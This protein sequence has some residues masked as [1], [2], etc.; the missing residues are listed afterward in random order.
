MCHH[1]RCNKVSGRVEI[2]W[3]SIFCCFYKAMK[4]TF[5]FIPRVFTAWSGKRKLF[6]LEIKAS[7]INHQRFPFV[8]LLKKKSIVLALIVF[9]VSHLVRFAGFVWKR[10]LVLC[11][12]NAKAWSIEWQVY[13]FSW[14]VDLHVAQCCTGVSTC[15]WDR[16]RLL[17]WLQT[18][19]QTSWADPESIRSTKERGLDLFLCVCVPA[20]ILSG[21]FGPRYFIRLKIRIHL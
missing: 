7:C 1:P 17:V 8:F 19:L 9:F 2:K 15:G 12:L 3:Y 4:K 20:L 14:L 5:L 21:P 18:A 16:S 6:K 10:F 13:S 11:G